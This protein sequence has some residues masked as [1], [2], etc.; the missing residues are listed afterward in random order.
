MNRK[1]ILGLT[2]IVIAVCVFTSAYTLSIVIPTQMNRLPTS[3]LDFTVT[4]SSNC[5][6]FLNSSV[7]LVCIPLTVAANE[8]WQLTINCT[9]MPG[10]N[11]GW[12]DVY[13]YRDYWVGGSNNTCIAGDIYPI[14]A[15]IESTECAIRLEQPYTQAFGESTQQSY[16]I[17]FVL[18]PGGPSAFHITYKPA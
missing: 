17:F 9:N 18:P 5:L 1:I 12:T 2:A 15:D 4:G 10:G 14:L 8:N 11:N 7:P 16:T 6:R 3:E 13:I